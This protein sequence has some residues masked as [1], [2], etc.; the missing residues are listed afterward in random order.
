MQY[1]ICYTV[2]LS[3]L[4][5]FPNIDSGHFGDN[6]PC[7][8]TAT[9]SFRVDPRNQFRTLPWFRGTKKPLKP[10]VHL[11]TLG[12]SHC[13][14]SVANNGQ[15]RRTSTNY[16]LWASAVNGKPH[17]MGDSL[18]LCIS[19]IGLFVSMLLITAH[20]L[21]THQKMIDSILPRQKAMFHWKRAVKRLNGVFP[22]VG[23]VFLFLGWTKIKNEIRA[24]LLHVGMRV[25][26]FQTNG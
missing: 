9:I 17:F 14:I 15:R 8:K 3:K 18:P 23:W 2:Y 24:D 1:A 6:F 13:W 22:R 21:S 26:C 5:Y 10:H 25:V 16:G 19:W 11:L 20:T 12:W 7:L 4:L